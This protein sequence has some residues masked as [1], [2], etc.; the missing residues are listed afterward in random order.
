MKIKMELDFDDEEL[1]MK[2]ILLCLNDHFKKDLNKIW[3]KINRKY[4][5]DAFNQGKSN[6]EL[7]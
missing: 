6:L 7:R 2:V 1:K 4:S 3:I 5:F